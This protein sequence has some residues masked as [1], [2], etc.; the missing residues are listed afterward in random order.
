MRWD[1]LRPDAIRRARR[2][3]AVRDGEATA[4]RRPKGVLDSPEHRGSP[5]AEPRFP[6]LEGGLQEEGL[7]F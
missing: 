7:F 1:A 2:A 3:G 4:E 5:P 6:Q